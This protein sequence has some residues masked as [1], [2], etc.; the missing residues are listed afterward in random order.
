MPKLAGKTLATAKTALRKANC[1]TGKVTR[2]KSKRVRTGRVIVEAEGRHKQAERRRGRPRR[3]P[4]PALTGA[5]KAGPAH[6]HLH[7]DDPWQGEARTPRGMPGAAHLTATFSVPRW[8][9]LRS[10]TPASAP[11]SSCSTSAQAAAA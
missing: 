10:R 2:V 5:D 7:G 11:A 1:K 8:R 9:A 6:G 4:R 3:Q